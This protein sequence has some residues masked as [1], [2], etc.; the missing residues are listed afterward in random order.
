MTTR[1][2]VV[3]ASRDS[4]RVAVVASGGMTE[5]VQT[6]NGDGA[7]LWKN[8]YKLVVDTHLGTKQ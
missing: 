1:R 5:D 7:Q 2:V 4:A 8:G 3:G 6:N